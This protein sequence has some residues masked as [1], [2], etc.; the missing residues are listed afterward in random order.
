[1]GV[2]N[3]KDL[4]SHVGHK[5][6]CVCYG[7]PPVNVS[8]ECIKCAEVLIDYDLEASITQFESEEN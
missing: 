3:F 5:I 7:D 6:E 4:M 1:M 2:S 8:V